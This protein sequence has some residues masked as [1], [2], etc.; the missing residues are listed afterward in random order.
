MNTYTHCIFVT[1][2]INIIFI[3]IYFMRSLTLFIHNKSYKNDNKTDGRHISFTTDIALGQIALLLFLCYSFTSLITKTAKSNNGTDDRHSSLTINIALR[4]G[5]LLVLS[6][7]LCRSQ[8]TW[9]K[10]LSNVLNSLMNF[11]T[12]EYPLKNVGL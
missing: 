9:H 12:T 5:A 7:L 1:I 10:K 3:I 4:L 11:Q 8:Q 2:I 6:L